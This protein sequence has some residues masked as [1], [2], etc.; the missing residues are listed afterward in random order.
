M[1]P[2]S[3]FLNQEIVNKKKYD[4]LRAFFFENFRQNLLPRPMVMYI[5]Y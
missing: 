1:E 3:Y 2:Y 5:N 4:A